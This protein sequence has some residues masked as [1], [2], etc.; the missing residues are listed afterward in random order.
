[1]GN[2][3]DIQMGFRENLANDMKVRGKLLNAVKEVEA[4]IIRLQQVMVDAE[5]SLTPLRAQR[6]AMLEALGMFDDES[7]EL[8]AR[9]DHEDAILKR[10][11]AAMDAFQAE[12]KR[13]GER[14]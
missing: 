8:K 9:Q 13:T 10:A 1:M 4:E 2:D 14:P 6:R 11:Q 7:A 12:W 3:E 5:C